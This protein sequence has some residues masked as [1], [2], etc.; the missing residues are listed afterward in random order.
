MVLWLGRLLVLHESLAAIREVRP[1][2][3]PD[4]EFLPNAAGRRGVPISTHARA[5]DDMGLPLAEDLLLQVPA[6]G[7]RSEQGLIAGEGAESLGLWESLSVR[8]LCCGCHLAQNARKVGRSGGR[9]DGARKQ[10]EEYSY[11]ADRE[12]IG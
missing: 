10:N 11:W 2:G 6:N 7:L 5:K 8:V 12:S 1:R 4:L 9:S 3:E